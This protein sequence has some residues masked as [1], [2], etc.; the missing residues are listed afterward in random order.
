MALRLVSANTTRLDIGDDGDWI[1]VKED[2]S[3]RDFNRIISTLPVNR[4]GL[5]TDEIDLD[6]ATSFAEALFD[7][8]VE[9]WS[10]TD[11]DSNKVKANVANYQLLDR[12]SSQ[13]I[14]SQLSDYF[15]GV[16]A[17]SDEDAQKSEESGV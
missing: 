13:L 4:E 8:F 3:R 11:G 1:E 2:L 15:N 9:D 10:V 17:V 14:D 16:I 7:V 6:T 12:A 5:N